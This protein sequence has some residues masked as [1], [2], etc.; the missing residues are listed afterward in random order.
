MTRT[1]NEEF[2]K[3]CREEAEA[4][5]TVV[6]ALQQPED[7]WARCQRLAREIDKDELIRSL[8]LKIAQMR[9]PRD[10]NLPLW[11]YVGEATNHGSGVSGAI[12]RV[13]GVDADSGNLIVEAKR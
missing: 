8:L 9:K 13:Y 7:N 2:E 11:S 3:A 1:N 6:V 5:E 12:C 10:R 4:G